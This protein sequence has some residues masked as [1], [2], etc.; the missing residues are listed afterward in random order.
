ML[1]IGKS[2]T[3]KN[4]AEDEC[5]NTFISDP[6]IVTPERYKELNQVLSI[7]TQEQLSLEVLSTTIHN[8]NSLDITAETTTA[9][10][11]TV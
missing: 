3:F 10:D 9:N 2:L 11:V 8:K 5:I 6:S 4:K 1:T 7:D